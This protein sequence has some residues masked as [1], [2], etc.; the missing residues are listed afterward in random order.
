MS[1]AHLDVMDGHFVPN[2][3]FGPQ[4]LSDLK[5][6]VPLFYDTHL[7]LDNPAEFIDAFADAGADLISIHLEPD[8]DVGATLEHIHERGVQRGIVL[9][10]E[11]PAEAA[12]PYLHSVD[13]VL[14]M[15]VQ[16][17]HGGQAFRS[18]ILPKIEQ[19]ARLRSDGNHAFHIEVD[20]GVD[21]A[22]AG[23][24]LRAG[25]NVLVTGTAFFRA[26][27]PSAFASEILS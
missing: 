24:C 18:D 2:L 27:D 11:T 1:W 15:T 7:M 10:P 3:T 26:H 16:P 8:Y 9:N 19:I 4:T 14:V 5:R 22:N 13:L 20:G 12:I 17:G 25:A 21:L 6:E 23:L